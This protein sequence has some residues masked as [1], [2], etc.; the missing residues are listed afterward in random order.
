MR[1]PR[2]TLLFSERQLSHEFMH[3]PP[4]EHFPDYYSTIKKPIAFA[5]IRAKL[6]AGVYDAFPAGTKAM[7]DDFH[8][9][10]VNA[11]RYNLKGSP[12]FNDAKRLDVSSSTVLSPLLCRARQQEGQSTDDFPPSL[13]PL[14][15]PSLALARDR[16][17]CSRSLPRRNSSRRH[18]RHSRGCRSTGL[19]KAA[20]NRLTSL[21][22]L[23]LPL[24]LRL[25]P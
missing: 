2:L 22:P 15:P 21:L 11:K 7:A 14:H 20:S 10:F 19:G 25:Q 5:E 12:I 18:T 16:C 1:E 6:D 13:R 23:P 24:R 17:E 9:M 3:L 8:Q 4:R